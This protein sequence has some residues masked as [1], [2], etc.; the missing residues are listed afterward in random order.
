M[1]EMNLKK[2]KKKNAKIQRKK[3]FKIFIKTMVGVPLAVSLILLGKK[4]IRNLT[5][6]QPEK[7]NGYS[8][9]AFPSGT[10]ELSVKK[11]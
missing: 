10:F 4:R 8:S 2:K 11:F 7:A 5:L 9:I 3:R 6:D 1:P